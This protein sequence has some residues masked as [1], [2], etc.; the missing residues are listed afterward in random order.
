LRTIFTEAIED[1]DCIGG[2]DTVID[3]LPVSPAINDSSPTHLVQVLRNCTLL[4]ADRLD[5]LGDHAL[6]VKIQML[7]NL[8]PLRMADDLDDIGHADEKIDREFVRFHLAPF[9]YES[10]A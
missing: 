4:T 10:P 6:A 5:N 7:Q 2:G 3:L 8:K 9:R 1:G